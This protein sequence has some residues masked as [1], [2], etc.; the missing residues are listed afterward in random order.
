MGTTLSVATLV[1]ALVFIAA[2]AGLGALRGMKKEL[3]RVGSLFAIGLLLFFLVP[4]LAKTIIL[5]VVSLIYPGGSTF[6]EVAGMIA[7]D[8]NLDA[9]VLGS[10]IETIL[11]L[12]ASLLVPFVFVALFWVCK[13]ISWPIFAL[14]C[15]IIR[16]V[17]KPF[18]DA[19]DNTVVASPTEEAGQDGAAQEVAATEDESVKVGGVAVT[20]QRKPDL[21]ERLIGAAIGL[22]VGL[23]LGAL[24]FMP[25][26]QLSKTVDTVGKDTVAELAGDE[27]A[28]MVFFWSES[29]AG[30]LYR[31]T[32]LESLF[33]LLHNSLAKVEIEDRVYEAKSLNEVLEIV[34]DVLA[35]A[36][37]LEDAD[38]QQVASVA[39]P[40]KGIVESV[41]DISLFSEQDKMG[42][43]RYVAREAL[44]ETAEEKV[45]AADALEA[46][47]KMEFAELKNDVL[48]AIDLIV[49]LDRHGLTDSKKLEK[50][51]TSI[52][53]D[54]FIDEGA[55]VIYELNLAEAVLP[56]AIDMVLESV[57]A[58]MDV[59]VVPHEDIKDFKSTKQDFKD[60]LKLVKE[61]AELVE[62]ADKLT[63]M[64]DVKAALN[65]VAKL[66]NSPFIAAETY[67]NLETTLIKNT[68]STAKVEE[69]IQTAVKEHIEEI[70]QA[71]GE[72][73]EID[74]E[75]IEK[76]QEAVSEYLAKPEEIKLEDIDTVI[77]KLEDGTLMEG[78]DDPEVLE[79]I[80]N[81]DFNLSDWMTRL[82]DAEININ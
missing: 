43:V 8:M 29:P 41:L 74:D 51:D 38:L 45:L 6:S 55:D 67:A 1:L 64:S 81:G 31:V 16:N 36:E 11:A 10:T 82:N 35:L 34:P 32:Q 53:T 60:L 20:K 50:L 52:F 25:L 9:A 58:E 75:T 24:T 71:V 46:V 47:E 44:S 57:L 2:E 48:G 7:A 17:R 78:M 49:V 62:D 59:K 72:D 3:C 37:D 23:F 54:A 79:D 14:V 56:S 15:L 42:L 69:T 77:T 28:D 73:V 26:T 40:I 66:K 63:T 61:L 76:V 22:V 21:T 4:G 13:L 18:P 19:A 5:T 27:V 70:K 39:E 80:K 65:K 12:V 33:G 30:S 68:V